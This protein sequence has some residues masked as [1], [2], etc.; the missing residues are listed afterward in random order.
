VKEHVN[1]NGEIPLREGQNF[2]KHELEYMFEWWKKKAQK[3]WEK[4]NSEGRVRSKLEVYTEE[5]I[6]NKEV[7]MVR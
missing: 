3:R 5:S 4:L 7:D 1:S 6:E 2:H